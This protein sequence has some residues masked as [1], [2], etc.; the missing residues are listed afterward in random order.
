MDG[1][2]AYKFPKLTERLLEADGCW[3]RK[4]DFFK[5]VAMRDYPYCSSWAY[6]NAHKI[7]TRWTHLVLKKEHMKLNGK[8]G[9]GIGKIMQD[10]LIKIHLMQ[11]FIKT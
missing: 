4:S 11:E 7:K 8:N 10:G 1:V 2:G 6:T 3:Q 5:D 9:R